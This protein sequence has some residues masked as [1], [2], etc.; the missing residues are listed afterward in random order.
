MREVVQ[1]RSKRQMKSFIDFPRDLYRHEPNYIGE[2]NL[3]LRR[4]LSRK[5]PFLEHSDTAL[6]LA[7]DSWDGKILGRIAAIYNTRH[8]DIQN[9]NT[10]FFGYFDSVD[11]KEVCDLLFNHTYNWLK[12]RNIHRLIGPTNFS[13]NNSCGILTDG[14]SFPNQV[15]M[16]YN[17]P[18]YKDLLES[19][20]FSKA[21]D[22][23]AY[24]LKDEP[25]LGKYS[26][27]M[28]RAESRMEDNGIRIRSIKAKSFD[29]DINR[30]REAYNKFNKN[31][32]GFIPLGRKEFSEMAKDLKQIMPYQLAQIVEK[33]QRLIGYIIAVPDF[34]QVLKRIPNGK[35]WPSGVF[36]IFK[37]SK[38][39]DSARIM[40]IGID[41][42]YRGTGLDLILYKR[43]TMALHK[44]NIY[45][46]EPSYVL[47]TNL[48]MNSL[49]IKIGGT[50]KKRFRLFQ[51]SI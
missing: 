31:N 43:I 44:E 29:S 8:L 27:I 20:G 11:D 24:H 35:L 19:Q 26:N 2:L 10:G 1:V 17:F 50:I 18:Y 25:C 39:I 21:I 22:L 4:K 16:P 34:N 38:K 9:D 14:F 51:K 23:Y 5:N 36:K 28:A 37:Y 46:C 48:A 32:W 42:E 41:D 6:F 47:E 45:Q 33:D 7:R 30:L 40:L 3:T 15:E 49:L 13:T 12:A